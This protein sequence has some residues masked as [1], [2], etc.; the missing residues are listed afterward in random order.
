MKHLP[1]YV[2]GVHHHN[3][4]MASMQGAQ[5]AHVYRAGPLKAASSLVPSTLAMI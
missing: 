4:M 2:P 1:H 5:L 3:T